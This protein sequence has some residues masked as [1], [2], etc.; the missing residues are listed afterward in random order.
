MMCARV[1]I[2]VERY[3]GRSRSGPRFLCHIAAGELPHHV[4]FEDERAATHEAI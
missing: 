3:V 2:D 1:P 4:I